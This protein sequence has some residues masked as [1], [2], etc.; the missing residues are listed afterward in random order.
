[1]H[2]LP[3]EYDLSSTTTLWI[4]LRITNVIVASQSEPE[5]AW[6]SL[7]EPE[8][9]WA[10]L[11]EPERAWAS[12]SEPERAWASLSEPERAWASLSE[13]ERAWASPKL[14]CL[15]LTF[16]SGICLHSSVRMS[17]M[18]S[19]HHV[20]RGGVA[21]DAGL[22]PRS[23]DVSHSQ[24]ND[25]ENVR[26]TLREALKSRREDWRCLCIEFCLVRYIYTSNFAT[27][28]NTRFQLPHELINLNIP[29]GLLISIRM[30][31]HYA[32]DC[33][34]WSLEMNKISK[35]NFHMR[36]LATNPSNDLLF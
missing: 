6:V 5:L 34:V 23:A 2:P 19:E 22:V 32:P 21:I 12:L 10:S 30:T 25:H 9:A 15:L 24:K 27:L 8:R 29:L 17:L 14:T 11:S 4:I 28:N 13:P 3:E 16:P 18:C 33:T 20:L 36:L 35:P 7:S 26:Q 1:M 31:G